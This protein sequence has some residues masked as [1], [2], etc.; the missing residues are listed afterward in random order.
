[1]TMREEI[2]PM[3]RLAAPLALTELGWMLMGI[4]DTIM[5]GR[6]NTAAVGGDTRLLAL[7]Q[8]EGERRSFS[9]QLY[10]KNEEYQAVLGFLLAV[11]WMTFKIWWMGKS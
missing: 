8:W 6:L 11:A 9:W 7:E 5:A 10:K 1:M 4:V 3:L 2:R